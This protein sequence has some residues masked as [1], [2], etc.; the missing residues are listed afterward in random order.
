M[1]LFTRWSFALNI[2]VVVAL[3]AFPKDHLKAESALVSADD[4]IDKAAQRA[5][6][7]HAGV[8]NPGY[9]Y[10]KVT[11][12]DE[13]DS[14]GKVKEHKKKVYRVFFQ[15][16]KTYVK[17]LEVNGHVPDA[18]DLRK[19]NENEL[20]VQQ[21]LG[22]SQVNAGDNRENFLTPDLVAR[23]DFQLTGEAN[24]NGRRAY[25]IAFQPK[26]PA[27]PARRLADKLLNRISGTLWIDAEESEVARADIQLKSEVDVLGG[28]AGC[29]RH[30]V[31]TMIRT[32]IADGI[33][34]NSFSSGDFEGRKL[35]DSMRIKTKSESSDFRPCTSR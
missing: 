1:V 12:T 8:A 26:N 30:L 10:T 13:L 22:Q 4:I 3:I 16:G 18:A 27:P 21:L 28:I 11:S 20:S 19:Q 9:T 33:W 17:L 23:F 7:A 5:Q 34:L 35:L 14:A 24:I 31:Y 2:A 29:L 6:Q 32:R 25:G 15:S